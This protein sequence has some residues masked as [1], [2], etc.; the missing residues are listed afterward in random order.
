[1]AAATAFVALL[2]AWP[3]TAQ[4][5]K[6]EKLFAQ[7]FEAAR[8]ALLAYGEFVDDAQ[9]ERVTDMG[10]ELAEVSAFRDYPFTFHLIDMPVPNAFALPGGQIFLTRGMLRM[11]LTDDE[12]AGLLGHEIGHVIENHGLR[13]QKRA[14]LL[15]ILGQALVI[16]VLV[17]EV[18][19]DAKPRNDGYYDPYAGSSDRGS[20]VQGA[21]AASMVTSELLLRGY[22]REFE[23]EADAAGQRLAALA[24]YNP[25]G[26]A[27]LM[28]KMSVQ[29]PQSK[30]YGY[31]ST[32]PFFD[33][34]VQ[35]AEARAALLQVAS[36]PTDSRVF[37]A[38][39]QRVLL[40]WADGAKLEP[41]PLAFAHTVALQTW[42]QG[43]AADGIRLAQLH[44]ARDLE[45]E[46][47]PLSRD[48]SHLITDYQ[49]N[50][51]EVRELTPESPL[52]AT[53]ENEIAE[54]EERRANLYEQALRVLAGGV[55]ETEFMETF[56]SNYPESSEVARVDL[57]L[58]EAYSRLGRHKEAVEH[59][60]HAA[61]AAP[62]SEA[63]QRARRGLILL[64][65]RLRDLAA[66]ERLTSEP[67]PEIAE[68]A[69]ARLDQLASSFERLEDGSAY[70][71]AFPDGKHAAAVT[72][73]LN[74]LADD[75]YGE[76]VLYQ[77]VGDA[78]Q[79]VTG[80]QRILVHAPFSPAAERLRQRMIVES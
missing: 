27:S 48:F 8:Q 12:L 61:D 2:Q 21:A 29:I 41:E 62:E 1:M 57:E 46:K 15:N 77:T 9:L 66:L 59:Y 65:T 18:N 38:K 17:N 80:I 63:G 52:I 78:A 30:E 79:A 74:H 73:R 45:S 26:T 34:R 37:R 76:V 54:F 44:A 64:S 13:T 25:T 72:A 3:T 5:I 6:D 33:Q 43:D 31:W 51:E 24:G 28:N 7:S 23:D 50:L 11:G 22:S 68:G 32:H 39:T 71:E 16:G 10:Y 40:D 69:A 75:L 67:D 58:G 14:R 36:R 19:R 20:R 70:I 56:L 49:S 55:Y 42:P 53:L 60:L 35:H 47:A 4:Q